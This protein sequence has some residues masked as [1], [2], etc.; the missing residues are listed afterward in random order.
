M[1]DRKK[2]YIYDQSNQLEANAPKNLA[3]TNKARPAINSGIRS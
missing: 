1:D 2:K 3:T